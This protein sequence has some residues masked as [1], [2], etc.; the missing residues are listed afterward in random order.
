VPELDG[1]S[2]DATL[3]LDALVDASEQLWA[4][5]RYLRA[6]PAVAAVS[7]HWE[8]GYSTRLPDRVSG[9]VIEVYIDAEL[10]NGHGVSCFL[11]LGWSNLWWHLDHS[12]RANRSAEQEYLVDFPTFETEALE[13]IITSLRRAAADLLATMQTLDLW[14][15]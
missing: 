4:I 7:V 11:D 9:R 1:P 10:R 8:S 6:H 15:I 14:S 5:R 12:V 13:T 3:L 2:R